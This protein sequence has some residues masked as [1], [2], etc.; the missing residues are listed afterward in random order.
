MAGYRFKRM[1]WKDMSPKKLQF[2]EKLLMIFFQKWAD[3]K[4][5]LEFHDMG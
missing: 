4:L 5:I 3:R 1:N 2:Q